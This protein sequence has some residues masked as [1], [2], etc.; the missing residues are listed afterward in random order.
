VQRLSRS[1]A[2][3]A[4]ERRSRIQVFTTANVGMAEGH[5]AELEGQDIGYA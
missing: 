2:R 3:V 4:T 5:S 1:G